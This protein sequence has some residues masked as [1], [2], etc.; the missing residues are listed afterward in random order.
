MWRRLSTLLGLISGVMGGLVVLPRINY[1]TWRVQLALNELSWL[2]VLLGTLAGTRRRASPVGRAFG[3][4]GAL[5]SLTPATRFGRATTDMDQSM[6]RA[7]GAGY[8][9]RIPPQVRQR[10]RENRWSLK[11]ALKFKTASSDMICEKKDIPFAESPL[12][13]LRLDAYYPNAAPPVGDRFPAIIVIHGGGWYRGD[14][15]SYF[16]AHNRHLASLGFAVFDIQYRFTSTDAAIWPA[17][18]EDVRS[19]IRWVKANADLYGVDAERVA[20]FGRSAGGQIALRAAYDA[21]GEHVD[22]SVAAV[23]SAY[24]P[25][26][27]RYTAW[28]YDERVIKLLGGRGEDVP[29]RYDD[30]SPM[31]FARNNLPPTLLM[32]GY[33]DTLVTPLHAEMLHNKLRLTNTPCAILRVPWGRHGFDAIMPGLGAQLTQYYVDRF[34]AGALYRTTTDD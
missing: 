23:V 8:I 24:A 34:L 1:A 17:Q 21:R 14:K 29:E 32:H 31:D 19:A 33:M 7:L 6:F 4:V 2:L 9:H 15:G 5:L 12:R 28:D 20:L 18:L 30:A 25:I 10:L 11:T 27:L 26:D 16:T 13:S 3:I 22:T